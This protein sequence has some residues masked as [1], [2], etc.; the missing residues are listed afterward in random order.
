MSSSMFGR[1]KE[2]GEAAVFAAA[3]ENMAEK[4]GYLGEK[5]PLWRFKGLILSYGKPNTCI[6]TCLDKIKNILYSVYDNRS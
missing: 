3:I 2:G 1:E 6:L 4:N 5:D